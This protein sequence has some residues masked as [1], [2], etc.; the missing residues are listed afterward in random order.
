MGVMEEVSQCMGGPAP[1]GHSTEAQEPPHTPC[2]PVSL[3]MPLH[4]KARE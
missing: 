1:G 2:G 3:F 4:S